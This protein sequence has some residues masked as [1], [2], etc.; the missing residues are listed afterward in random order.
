[1][2]MYRIGKIHARGVDFSGFPSL[3]SS[4]CF[5]STASSSICHGFAPDLLRTGTSYDKSSR[6]R[7]P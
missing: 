2:S 4:A 7:D 5:L 1:M 6:D 3:L